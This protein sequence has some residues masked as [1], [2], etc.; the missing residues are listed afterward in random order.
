MATLDKA[1]AAKA[2]FI[3]EHGSSLPIIGVGIKG[4]SSVGYRIR[5]NLVSNPPD[6]FPDSIGDDVPVDYY[7]IGTVRPL[8]RKIGNSG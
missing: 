1:R 7:L 5:V 8:R 3:R 4:D 2:E 6:D